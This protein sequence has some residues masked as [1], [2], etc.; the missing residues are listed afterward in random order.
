MASKALWFFCLSNKCT[1][2]KRGF[3]FF[4]Q[5]VVSLKHLCHGVGLTDVKFVL[6]P[7]K[8]YIHG[9]EVK[10]KPCKNAR[11]QNQGK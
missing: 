6:A 4:D 8:Q 1:Y 10:K 7:G 5:G 9:I 3:R 2:F 11:L